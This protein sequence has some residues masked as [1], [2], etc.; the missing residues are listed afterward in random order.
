MQS[1]APFGDTVTQLHR[2]TG[3]S[4]ALL[5][6]SE[7]TAGPWLRFFFFFHLQRSKRPIFMARGPACSSVACAIA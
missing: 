5:K 3:T 1:N 7:E 6:L 4:S 2:G